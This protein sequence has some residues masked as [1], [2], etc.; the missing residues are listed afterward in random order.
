MFRY[1]LGASQATSHCL[2][3][4]WLDY[5]RIYV[6]RPQW[7]N[8]MMGYNVQYCCKFWIIFFI[9]DSWSKCKPHFICQPRAMFAIISPSF[10]Q[11]ISIQTVSQVDFKLCRCIHNSLWPSDAIWCY[12]TWPTLAQLKAW[13]CQALES[14]L[15]NHQWSLVTFTGGQFLRK[16]SKYLSLIWLKI[17]Q[18]QSAAASPRVHWVNRIWWLYRSTLVDVI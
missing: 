6:T 18:L 3:Q 9:V 8:G 12:K 5:W 11:V 14:M 1:W 7:V 10:F 16:C 4:L 17:L 15:T 2:N 13:C